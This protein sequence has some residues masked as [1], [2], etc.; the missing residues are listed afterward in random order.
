ML[1]H[2]A[3]VLTQSSESIVWRIAGDNVCIPGTGLGLFLAFADN[4]VALA[5]GSALFGFT[6]AIL[7][8]TLLRNRLIRA[9][10]G[11][12]ALEVGKV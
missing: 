2:T 6:L 11:K 4:R 10:M 7:I 9:H 5:Y 3:E 12:I 1:Y 8:I